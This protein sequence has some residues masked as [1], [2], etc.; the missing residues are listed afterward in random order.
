MA[1]AG[2]PRIFSSDS[3]VAGPRG[4]HLARKNLQVAFLKMR[5]QMRSH[6]VVPVA[7]GA[8]SIVSGHE[9][10]NQTD[11]FHQPHKGQLPSIVS[12]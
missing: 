7:D 9:D 3:S 11:T 5:N 1:F 6:L 2:T 10:R 4:D 8:T 12:G